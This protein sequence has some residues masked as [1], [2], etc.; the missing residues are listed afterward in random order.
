MDDDGTMVAP[1]VIP[2]KYQMFPPQMEGDG[3][4]FTL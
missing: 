3:Q 1:A 4:N 2:A